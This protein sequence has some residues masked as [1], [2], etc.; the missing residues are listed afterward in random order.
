MAIKV[1]ST[2]P[3]VKILGKPKR[4]GNNASLTWDEATMT[5]DE[6]TFTW[7]DTGNQGSQPPLISVEI[8]S[9]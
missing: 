7:D 9:P 2:K 5:W 8:Q 4:T 1:Q 3:T 6:A